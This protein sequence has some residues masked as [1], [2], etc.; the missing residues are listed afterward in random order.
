MFSASVFDIME[1]DT[2]FVGIS[3]RKSKICYEVPPG[4]YM[5]MVISESADFMKATVSAG[6]TYYVLV[7]SRTGVW[8]TR[9]SLKPLRQSEIASDKFS[10]WFK[11]TNLLEN[12]PESEQWAK[13]SAPDIE[14]KRV[15]YLPDWYKLYPELID[16]MTLYSEDGIK[17]RWKRK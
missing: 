7:T 4:E 17:I 12:T 10:R 3:Y 15:S 8:K 5:F 16:S 13:D 2:E 1:S 11:K 6:K 9:F 14:G